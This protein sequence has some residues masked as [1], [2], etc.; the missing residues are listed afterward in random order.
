MEIWDGTDDTGV[1]IA[2]IDLATGTL[3]FD[4]PY[5]DGLYIETTGVGAN[6]VVT[7]E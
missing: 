3:T 6:V 2:D 5:N 4:L 1:Q 7:Y